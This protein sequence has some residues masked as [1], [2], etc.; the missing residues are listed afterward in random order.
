[1]V[2]ID[3]N[4]YKHK[5]TQKTYRSIVAEI[6]ELFGVPI[7]YIPKKIATDK[8]NP[9]NSDEGFGEDLNERSNDSINQI[10]GED[11]N[12]S[13]EGSVP[14]KATLENY[15]GYDGVH[16]M[17][18]NFGF[19]MEDEITLNIEIETWRNLM[20]RCGYD[21]Q[22]PMEG[23]LILF[24]LARAKNGKPQIFEIKYCN[25]SASYFAFGELM[26]FA[27]NCTLWE[28]SHETLNTGDAD[29]D[30]LNIDIDTDVIRKEVGDNDVIQEKSEEV[31][32]YDPNDPFNDKFD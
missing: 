10:Y 16:N 21:M 2:L 9:F 14:M 30:R 22:K 27:L 29:V 6:I 28:Y 15:E 26:V 12:I 20:K 4:L 13:F 7:K 1:M 32:R 24:D 31:T 17:F 11:V 5:D 18:S 23:D 25:E 19:S 3:L 8:L